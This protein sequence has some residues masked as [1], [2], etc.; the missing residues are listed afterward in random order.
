[1]KRSLV[2]PMPLIALTLAGSLVLGACS[3][4]DD[5]SS[6]STAADS[7][8]QSASEGAK[9]SSDAK[10]VTIKHA[11]G[12]DT[13]PVKPKKVV[14]MGTS[15]DN[16]L[17]LGITPDVVVQSPD[18]AQNA[19][20]KN[21]KLKDV[22]KIDADPRELPVEKIAAEK[23]DF[24]V[25]DFYRINEDAYNKLKDVAPTL[26]GMGQDPQLIGWK[27]QLEALGK[28]YQD[29]DKVK[30]VEKKDSEAF[31][32]AKKDLKGLEGKSALVVQHRSGNF[33]VITDEANPANQFFTDLG[34]K[35]PAGYTDGS[36][37]TQQGR[38][39]ISPENIDK[40]TADFMV[41]FAA[42][43][44]DAVRAV[45]GY[46]DLKQV[47]SGAT[48]EDNKAVSSALYVPS[49][50][51]REWALKEIKPELK[52]VSDNKSDSKDDSDK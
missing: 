30:D 22:K 46:N 11:W 49:L 43:G 48:V 47:K 27:P 38:A 52:K 42:D 45:P 6:D 19:T 28:I 44:M 24:I 12:E 18:D 32:N 3:N 13:Y 14:A 35:L 31:E 51:S 5:S 10:E 34:M 33:G 2:R 21:D 17:A 9:D 8:S 1:M 26:P 7:T 39:M 29:E 25:G 50:L 23:P 4:D 15:V 36:I 16:L 20:W 41:L 37:P 40:L